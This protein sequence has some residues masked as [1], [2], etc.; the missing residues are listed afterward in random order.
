MVR[1]AEGHFYDPGKHSSCPWCAKPL[2]VGGSAAESSESKTR[3][4]QQPPAVAEAPTPPASPATP[5]AAPGATKRVAPKEL[6]IDPVVGWLV[7]IDGK[8]KGRDFRIHTERN[9]LGRSA[10]QDICITGDDTIS[11]EKHAIL[12]F[13]PKKNEFWI[14]PGESSGLLYINGDAVYVPA[15]LKDRDTIEVGQ[16]RL[17]FLSFVNEN[18]QWQ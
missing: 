16:T 13:D 8:D 4:V 2:D 15:R 17:A 9:F 11:R 5:A 6:G 12:S 7:C 14:Q 18:F 10:N 1:C 3:P